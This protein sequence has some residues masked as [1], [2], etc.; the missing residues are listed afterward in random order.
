MHVVYQGIGR[1]LSGPVRK[2]IFCALLNYQD[3]HPGQD[4]QAY[5][6]IGKRY[7]IPVSAGYKF[8]Y[9]GASKLWLTSC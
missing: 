5:Y 9:E 1:C 6:V 7:K 8:A 3:N 2:Q 4:V